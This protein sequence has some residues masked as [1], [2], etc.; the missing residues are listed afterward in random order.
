MNLSKACIDLST[1]FALRGTF[2]QPE[3]DLDVAGATA[4]TLGRAV[5]KPINFL[6][7]LLPVVEDDG[8][9]KANPCITP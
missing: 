4:R 8:A 9:D 1:P 5:L 7:E 2:A 6:G 3:L